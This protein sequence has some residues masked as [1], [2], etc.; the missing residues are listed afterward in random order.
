MVIVAIHQPNY[1]PWLG[2]FYKIYAS[3]IFIIL[4]DVQYSK[5]GYTNRVQVLCNN[6]PTWLTVPVKIQYGQRILDVQPARP[7]WVDAHLSRIRDYYCKARCFK[8]VFPDIETAYRDLSSTRLDE[9]NSHF[10]RWVSRRLALDTTFK[11]ASEIDV[12]DLSGD[13]RLAALVRATAGDRHVTYLSGSGGRA[14]QQPETY[15]DANIALAYTDFVPHPYCQARRARQ[16]D[17]V[18][19]HA[20]LSVIDALCH[21]GWEGVS[22]LVRNQS[23]PDTVSG[24]TTAIGATRRAD[25]APAL[26]P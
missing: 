5:N 21:V 7:A 11:L 20:G 1:V 4:N 15:H 13:K 22:A 25:H 10:I 17:T 3:D 26:A 19:F 6:Q 9:I 8:E 2:Y 12:G 18:P 16:D 24:G 23:V 14:Y